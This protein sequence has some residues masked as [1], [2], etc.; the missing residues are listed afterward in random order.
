MQIGPLHVQFHRTVRVAD[1]WSPANLPP[2]LGHIELFKVSD[3]KRK[4]PKKWE[5]EGVFMG[6]AETEAMWMSFASP[7]PVALMVGAGAINALTGAKLGTKLTPGGYLVTPPQPWLDGWKNEDGSVFQFVATAYKGGKGKTVGE[8]LIGKESE[9]GG[10]GL[11]LFE[12]K[13]PILASYPGLRTLGVAGMST[14]DSDGGGLISSS[15]FMDWS[16]QSATP[17]AYMVQN[18]AQSSTPTAS[19]SSGA[20]RSRPRGM[21]VNSAVGARHLG[22]AKRFSE[23]G[24]GKGGRIEQKVYA[25][26]HGIEVWRATPSQTRAIYIV[27]AE[28]LAQI[29]GRPIEKP[30]TQGNYSGPYFQVHDAGHAD[31][32][33]SP[34]FTGLKTVFSK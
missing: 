7:S 5:T 19:A 15:S 31:V 32:A 27:D 25:D 14:G 12:P 29:T 6:L 8:Q 34:T 10:L 33:G 3:F 16:E 11:A 23:M 21:Q 20:L 13:E 9:T 18:M 24:I 30:V 28:T 2:S 17:H 1:G 26:P 22:S 4:C